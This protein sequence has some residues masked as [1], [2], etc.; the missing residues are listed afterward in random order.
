M[1]MMWVPAPGLKPEV[2]PPLLLSNPFHTNSP[3]TVELTTV[4][5]LDPTLSHPQT[6]PVWS[7]KIITGAFKTGVMFALSVPGKRL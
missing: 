7:A 6:T 4:M 1:N 3:S 5:R 2:S